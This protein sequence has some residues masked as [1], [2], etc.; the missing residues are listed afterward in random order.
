ME[1]GE[2]GQLKQNALHFLGVQYHGNNIF[3]M[4][5][6]ILLLMG[7]RDKHTHCLLIPH[8]Y[9]YSEWTIRGLCNKH[10]DQHELGIAGC[11]SHE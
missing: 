2:M 3:A 5:E 4:A 7:R 10:G 6:V 8:A 1:H 11:V 9:H